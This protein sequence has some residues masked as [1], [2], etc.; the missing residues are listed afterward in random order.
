VF[1]AWEAR[2]E[3]VNLTANVG[4]AGSRH[5]VKNSVILIFC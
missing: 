1:F 4:A 2:V 5:L 3:R